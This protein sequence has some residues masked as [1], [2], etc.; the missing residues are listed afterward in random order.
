MRGVKKMLMG[1]AA[2]AVGLVWALEKPSANP[3]PTGPEVWLEL[4]GGNVRLD[5]LTKDLEAI[6]AAGISGVHLFHIFRPNGRMHPGSKEPMPCMGSKWEAMVR[7]VGD[8]C[9]RLGLKLVLQNCP[10]WSQSGGPWIPPERAMRDLTF[11][12]RDLKGGETLAELPPVPSKFADADSDWRDICVLAFPTPEGDETGDLKPASKEGTGD[13]IVYRFEH[14][15]VVRTM[16]LPRLHHWNTAYGYHAPWR[17]VTLEAKTAAGW[18][19]VLDS[20]IPTTNWR[21]YVHDISFACDEAKS[22]TWRYRIRHDFPFKQTFE[23]TFS[24]AARLM[25]WQAKAGRTLRSLLF[26]K[27]A[28]QGPSAWIDPAKVVDLTGR[29][30]WTAPAGRWTVLR[31]GHVN[32]K[33]VNAPAP[34][35]A[36]GWECDKLDPAGIETHFAGYVGKLADG[37]LANR[38]HGMVVDSW[39]CWCQTWTAKMEDYYRAAN[40]EDLRA[41]LPA[42]FGWIVGSPERTEAFLTRWRRTVGDLVTGNYFGRMAEL[43]HGKGLA[44]YYETAFGDI[45]YGDLLEYWK[46]ADAPMCE[47]WYPHV[48]VDEG[49]CACYDYK[50]IR[51]CASAA[52]VYGKRRVSAEAFTGN[53]IRW[54]EDFARMQDDANRHFARGVTHLVF[55]CYTHQP[56]PQAM[57]PGNCMEGYNG[58][59]FSRLQTWWKD[60]PEFAGFLTRCEKLLEEG[61]PSQDVLWYL[62][63]AV[64]HK[65]PELFPFP[66]GFRADYLNHD[67]LTNRLTVRD[68]VFAIP[69]GTTWKVLWVPETR[70]ML[71][72]TKSALDRLAAAGGKV[73][74][75]DKT[76]LVQA[77]AGFQKDVATEP[78]LG[79]EPSEDFMWIHRKVDRGERYFVAAGTNGYS[80]RVTFRAKGPA[81]VYDPVTCTRRDW[82]NGSILE[83]P[84]SRSVFVDFCPS[85]QPTTTEAKPV[86]GTEKTCAL[87]DF[88]LRF[89]PGWGAPEEVKL[90]APVSWT[91]IPGFSREAKAYSGTVV[92]ETAFDIDVTA[93]GRL[94]VTTLDLGRVASQAKVLVNG[95]CVGLLW[96]APYRIDL[97]PY[98]VRGRNRLRLEVTN[99]WRNRV[100][101]DLGQPEKDRKTWIVNQPGYNPKADDPLEP[102]GVL[103][104]VTLTTAERANDPYGYKDLVVRDVQCARAVTNAA[105]HLVVDFGRDAIG[106]LEV[107]GAAGPFEIV[108]G[109]MTNAE[110]RVAN[111]HPGS[112]IR[113]QTLKSEKPEGWFRPA[114]KPDKW[115]L[116]GY[117]PKVSPAILL[118]DCL[119]L[120]FPFRYA[121][122]VRLP[123]APDP[124]LL[125]QKAV[126]YPIDM[127]RSAFDC[128]DPDLVR[129]HD[130]CK[131]SVLATSFTGIYVDGDR[132]RT[133]YEAD[134]YINQ[135]AH[136]AIDDDCSMA[137][138]SFEW[139]MDYLTWPTEWKQHM[140]KMA[141]ADWMWTGDTRSIARFYDW[142]RDVKLM[143][144]FARPTDGLLEAGGRNEEGG[145]TGSGGHRR[146][147]RAGTGRI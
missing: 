43:A 113:V 93:N 27:P 140:V 18:T 81:T 112:T 138:R 128:S 79:D 74:Y 86:P 126:N 132:E 124:R 141:W 95:R 31:F 146:L 90:A 102:A 99:T 41:N 50:P 117:N 58:T 38:L 36:T 60:M 12:R 143:R 5:G 131:Y 6:K 97:T 104:P 4:M 73:V 106:W 103:G 134:G 83:L 57:P 147:A 145:E 30:D 68:G 40:G 10:G 101:Y 135:M 28:K 23:P 118:P 82:T 19:T 47:F 20:P 139:L 129:V 67:V 72:A 65:P 91:E 53:G 1:L 144:G 13:E 69:E 22:D 114:M 26:E 21:D 121:E 39:E 80:G 136:Y 54:D 25:D 17:H 75:G 125:V 85:A 61:L 108:I 142:L 137:R 34:K 127:G 98:V 122:I 9:R 35:E 56:D 55:H 70:F 84:P 14:P 76:A 2:L 116:T 46:Y 130:F 11:V 32:A 37:V 42:L 3:L 88:T 111:P 100:I 115:N 45:I 44:C 52:H 119:G 15:V 87:R 51:P 78:A 48:S 66:E 92:Y 64:D 123:S 7:H 62:G 133:P 105:S 94:P 109:E 120:V 16:S 8:E 110:G 71:P 77:L 59:P 24:A 63:D 89:A 49:G 96:C 29:T 33:Y 107:G